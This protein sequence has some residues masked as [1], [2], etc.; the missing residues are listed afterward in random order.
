MTIYY[1]IVDEI[2]GEIKMSSSGGADVMEHLVFPDRF[3]INNP[4]AVVTDTK[5]EKVSNYYYDGVGISDRLENLA[6]IDADTV[7]ANGTDKI[8]ISDVEIGSEIFINGVSQGTTDDSLVELT[9]D[10]VGIYRIKI[11][12]IPYLDM[13]FF[14]N[15]N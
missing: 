2:S 10:T 7:V 9:F 3:F 6:S 15:A 5:L 14:V 4:V 13:E 1:V 11:S 12:L 8:S